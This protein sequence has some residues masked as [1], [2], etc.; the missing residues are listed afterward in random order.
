MLQISDHGDK[1]RTRMFQ[2]RG[3]KEEGKW[4]ASNHRFSEYRKVR[5]CDRMGITDSMVPMRK[6]GQI[7]VR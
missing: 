1:Y 3:T 6:E 5:R 7:V 2:S 4:S